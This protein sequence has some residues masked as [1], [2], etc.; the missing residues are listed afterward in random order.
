MEFLARLPPL[1][2]ISHFTIQ[3]QHSSVMMIGPFTR[4]YSGIFKMHLINTKWR[5]EYLR[6]KTLFLLG[7]QEEANQAQELQVGSRHLDLAES[8]VEEVDGQV[9]RLL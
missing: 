2:Q 1:L 6:E 3:C 9:E 7:C 4:P 8:T 5:S